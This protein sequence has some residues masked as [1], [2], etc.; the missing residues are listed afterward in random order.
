MATISNH[1]HQKSGDMAAELEIS[2]KGCKTNPFQ[3]RFSE[4]C[5][6]A[7]PVHDRLTG[8]DG[9][10][11]KRTKEIRTRTEIISAQINF[12]V[13][14]AAAVTSS[15]TT[16]NVDDG[17]REKNDGK[18][19]K[20]NEES[21]DEDDKECFATKDMFDTDKLE[22]LSQFTSD[23]GGRKASEIVLGTR[24]AW[25]EEAAK[26]LKTED[27]TTI[28]NSFFSL[29]DSALLLDE[30]KKLAQCRMRTENPF[31]D[32]IR[33]IVAGCTADVCND[34]DVYK[35]LRLIRPFS[36]A[37]R[38]ED[39]QLLCDNTGIDDGYSHGQWQ[40][41]DYGSWG[42]DG[43]VDDHC[44]DGDGLNAVPDSAMDTKARRNPAPLTAP[45]RARTALPAFMLD[46]DDDDEYEHDEMAGRG[47]ASPGLKKGGVRGG[48]HTTASKR[49]G[50]R[51]DGTLLAEVKKRMRRTTSKMTKEAAAATA[52]AAAAAVPVIAVQK[53][54]SSR[55]GRSKVT[56]KG[57]A[58]CSVQ[59]K[60]RRQP[61]THSI[62]RSH[63]HR[64]TY[65]HTHT[66]ALT[67]LNSVYS[68]ST[69]HHTIPIS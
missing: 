22:Q 40:D 65:P 11:E 10:L 28:M 69:H 34:D 62:T 68:P 26:K 49:E 36:F 17:K 19:P 45:R 3:Q 16:K 47:V 30:A 33:Q 32:E 18:Q 51:V 57:A 53:K 67:H 25:V 48:V 37:E 4:F 56:Y 31:V 43:P 41:D 21:E 58:V 55:V 38:H 5:E 63:N 52:A 59:R 15:S 44:Y 1:K 8:N 13:K 27:L 60:Q 2:L 23:I 12:L 6:S 24:V 7:Q 66:H 42:G 14:E 64:H 29:R 39:T 9:D 20:K 61:L 50:A 46:S 54:S 35:Y